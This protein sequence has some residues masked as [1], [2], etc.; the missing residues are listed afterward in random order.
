[1]HALRLLTFFR[2]SLN[3]I[4]LTMP[5]EYISVQWSGDRNADHQNFFY[6]RL[7]WYFCFDLLPLLLRSC[8]AVFTLHNCCRHNC[9]HFV[10]SVFTLLRVLILKEEI[11]LR[12]LLCR[13]HLPINSLGSLHDCCKRYEPST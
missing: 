1:M 2:I 12:G 4:S 11:I 3:I 8:T 10:I 5:S 9:F 7:C 6:Y 13:R